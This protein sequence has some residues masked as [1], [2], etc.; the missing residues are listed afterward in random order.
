MFIVTNSWH[1]S[2][3]PIREADRSEV[4]Y[5]FG[6]E[7]PRPDYWMRREMCRFALYL[8]REIPISSLI[9]DPANSMIHQSFSSHEQESPLNG[10]GFGL[11]WY[12]PDL[13]DEPALFKDVTPAW[14]NLNLTNLA[15]VTRSRCVVAHVRAATPGLGVAQSNCHPFSWGPFSFVHNGVV[16]GYVK[17]KRLFLERL[18][19]KAFQRISGSTDSEFFFALFSDH[20]RCSGP[21]EDRLQAMA[22]ALASTIEEVEELR[23]RTGTDEP[24]FLNLA[25]TDGYSGVCA[26]YCSPGRAKAHTLYFCTGPRCRFGDDSDKTTTSHPVPRAVIVASEPLSQ[27]R[28]WTSLKANSLLLI[29]RDLGVEA[30]PLAHAEDSPAE[31]PVFAH[32]GAM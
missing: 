1:R 21:D 29:N 22:S 30:R 27:D 20:Y 7:G 3:V 32:A 24:S 31:S 25:V 8:G 5:L 23:R 28:N 4:L 6:N 12:V 13:S 16:G 10:D 17:N 15:R 18:S 2:G 9:T 11:A 14:N 26:R 19:T